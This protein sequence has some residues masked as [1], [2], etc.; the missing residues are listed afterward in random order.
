[1]NTDPLIVEVTRGGRVESR[2]LV[3]AAIADAD[4]AI[5]RS[6][7]DIDGAVYP[8]S[9]IKALQ[10]LPLVESGAAEALGLADRHVALAC[11][12]H[13]GEAIHVECAGEMLAAAGLE[14]SALECG[15]QP[16]AL[17]AD[18]FRLA[19][20]R[21]K[22]SA[23]YNN[24]SGK[25]A[26]FL[27]LATHLGHDP[28]GYAKPDHPVQRAIAAILAEATGAAHDADNRGIDGCSIPTYAIPLGALASAFARF[29]ASHDPSAA[30]AAAMTR[31]RDACFAHPEMVAGTGRF[32]T[33][34]MTAL[35]GRVFTKTGAE[36]VYVAAFPELGV[37]LAL[38]AR[39]GTTRA[40]E[41]ATAALVESLL[42][43]DETESNALKGLANPVLRNWNRIEVGEIRAAG[44][45]R[46]S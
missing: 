39:D 19:R 46:S 34:L 9:A 17:D 25:H 12:S 10:A 41:V 14:E 7:G 42:E 28:T 30:R 35:R 31:I 23:I 24:C 22:P 11:A 15:P 29:G 3:D 44:I 2:H 43:L 38:K 18:R 16:P 20:D 33:T 45:S 13:N 6:H 4:D 8:R 40:A 32:D 1:M 21:R 37:G 36:G 27:C 26:G 5:V